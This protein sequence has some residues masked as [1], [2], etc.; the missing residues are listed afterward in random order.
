VVL[1]NGYLHEA[2]SGLDGWPAGLR[3][4]RSDVTPSI[5]TRRPGCDSRGGGTERFAA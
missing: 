3:L 2:A 1:V 5:Q 4:R